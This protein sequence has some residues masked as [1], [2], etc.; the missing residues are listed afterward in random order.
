MQS[1]IRRHPISASNAAA[2]AVV[3]FFSS[4]HR[5]RQLAARANEIAASGVS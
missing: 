5:D 3:S 1:L 4:N 2:A